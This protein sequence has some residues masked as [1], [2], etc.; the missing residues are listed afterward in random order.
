MLPL[1]RAIARPRVNAMA[2]G[3][4]PLR[5]VLVADNWGVFPIVHTEAWRVQLLC[6]HQRFT[7]RNAQVCTMAAGLCRPDAPWPRVLAERELE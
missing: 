2:T 5:V 1:C 4:A 3:V 6:V 7:G